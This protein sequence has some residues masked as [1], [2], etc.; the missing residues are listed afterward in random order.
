MHWFSWGYLVIHTWSILPSY[1]G[2]LVKTGKEMVQRGYE[3]VGREC[4]REWGEVDNVSV[5]DAHI[6]MS[7]D[8]QVLEWRQWLS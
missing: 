6:V 3:M 2:Y 8:K 4:F 5:E 7:L 1:L